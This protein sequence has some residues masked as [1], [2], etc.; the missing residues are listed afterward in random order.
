MQSVEIPGDHTS[1]VRINLAQP[2][3]EFT[4]NGTDFDAIGINL[5]AG[6]SYRITLDPADATT[7]AK[8]DTL[9]ADI[10][11]STGV[12]LG[13]SDDDSGS[14][15]ASVLTFTPNTTGTYFIVV[16]P[17][18]PNDTAGWWTLEVNAF[19]PP[20]DDFGATIDPSN[21]VALWETRNGVVNAANDVDTIALSLT[22]GVAVDITVYG[23]DSGFYGE[24]S[25]VEIL[26]FLNPLGN[27]VNPAAYKSAHSF[28]NFTSGTGV[29]AE[30]ITFTPSQ[31][32]IYYV[33]VGSNGG[34]GDYSVSVSEKDKGVF[35]IRQSEPFVA[36]GNAEIDTFFLGAVDPTVGNIFTDRNNDGVTT[37]T[38]SIP[39]VSPVFSPTEHNVVNSEWT[40]GYA[41]ASGDI[42]NTY[43]DV[44][45][46]ISSFANINFVQVPD[47]GVESGTF[48]IGTTGLDIGSASGALINGWSGFPEWMT[49]GETWIN[50]TK[51]AANLQLI[52]NFGA[53]GA[54]LQNLLVNRTIHEFTH[55]LGLNHPDQS[56]IAGS[57]NPS[58]LGQEFSVMSRTNS[59]LVPNSVIADLFPQTL[60]WLDIQ[61]I[62]AAYGKNTTTTSGDEVF[63]FDTSARHFS[64]IWDAGGEDEISVAGSG[65]VRIDLTP[66]TW[67]NVGTVINYYDQNGAVTARVSQTVFIAPDT[68]IENA[69]AGDG[70]DTVSGNS[71]GN[72]LIGGVGDD[73]LRGFD[74]A[75]QLFGGFGDDRAEGG[76]GDDK[77]RSGPGK[78]TLFG[79]AGNDTLG[80]SNRNDLLNGESGND[81]LLGSNGN[82]RLLGEDGA[83]TLL[84]GNGRDTLT[85]GAGA[86]RMDGGAQIDTVSYATAN[87][88]V[89]V[90]LWAGDGLEGDALGDTLIAIENL[91]GSSHND[92]LIGSD[93]ANLI[94]GRAGDDLI[95][96]LL[97]DDLL[98]GGDGDDNLFGGVGDDA[99]LFFASEAGADVVQDFTAGAATDD[100]IRL[101]G[102]GG[103]LDDFADITANAA[104]VGGDVVIDLGGGDSITL[105]GVTLASLH[106]D[107]FTF[108]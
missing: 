85:G 72:I 48:R 57:V 53:T 63:L 79:G 21:P 16:G 29:D 49:A 22:A 43:M 10:L 3:T 75:D 106:A 33:Q 70:D 94:S 9:I 90:R 32:G 45:S 18:G 42:L 61:A 77:I 74:G 100:V 86:D 107:D 12:S 104:Q 80:A 51:A 46:A 15:A 13:F 52:Q 30:Q 76:N 55:N 8:K 25:D 6:Q 5:I 44:I 7:M 2:F 50:P 83:D 96:G 97:G 20:A 87:D 91:E 78:D 24:L 62:Q 108:G 1:T 36:T 95:Q 65:N 93:G 4:A 56:A 88:K 99:F 81:L 101:I 11:T 67:Q 14:G 19:T 37:L 40:V 41:P 82:D 58:L 26:G 71:V 39:G 59:G 66:G 47:A 69:T 68:V 34:V 103:S 73:V 102:F 98:A 84:G 27:A 28:G 64:T 105:I 89:W 23:N 92:K 60:M 38:Y 17:L 54:T 31:T 35:S